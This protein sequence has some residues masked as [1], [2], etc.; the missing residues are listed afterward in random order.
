MGSVRWAFL[1]GSWRPSR[2]EWMLANRC[3]QREERD[4]IGQFVFA[5]DAKSAMA[6]RLLLR[7]FVCERM[8]IPW[9]EIRLERSPRGKPYLA[10]PLKVRSDSG[11]EP[12][13]WSFNLSHQG[14]YAVLAAEQGGQVGV[15]IMKNTMPGTSSVPEFFRIMTRQFTAYEWSVIQ[16][17]GTEH[18]QLAA[19]Y[20]HWALK[21]SFIKAIGTG[22]GFN[23]QRV[24]FHL[25]PEPLT[26]KHV[27]RQTKM[28]LDEEEEED[29]IFEESLLDA[30]HHVAV[31]FGPTDKTGSELFR[32][33]LPPASSFALL[34]F[35]DLTASASPL[36]EED[37][38]CWDSFEM[39]AEAPQRQR[40]THT[41]EQP[42]VSR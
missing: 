9:S 14:D 41:S 17:A 19:F 25:A 36:T 5:K 42:P 13:S 24:E 37:P 8:G 7:R 6:G 11:T 4:R 32:P 31:A 16:S 2:S 15:D 39:K 29:W 3:I 38:A 12:L 22:L 18:L 40:D 21:E 33:S 1:C 28:H 26:Q 30:D 20:R 35:S 27:L 34:S 23:L 10:A